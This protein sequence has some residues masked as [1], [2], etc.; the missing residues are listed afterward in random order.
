[1]YFTIFGLTYF[2]AAIR[3]L[4]LIKADIFW[5]KYYFTTKRMTKGKKAQC[6]KFV[7]Q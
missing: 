4:A 5:V 3:K 6:F 1:M 2:E 7:S